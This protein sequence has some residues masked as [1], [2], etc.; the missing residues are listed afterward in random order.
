MAMLHDP[1]TREAIKAR[2]VALRPDSPRRWGRMTTDQML[3]HLNAG[4]DNCLGRH[5]VEPLRLPLPHALVKFVVLNLPWRKGK[6]PTAREFLAREQY[7]FEAEKAK[8]LHLIDEV[9]ARPLDGAWPDS[10]FMGPMTGKDWSR[11]GAK[12]LDHH[13]TQFGV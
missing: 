2:I 8:L 10:P 5:H 13:L 6:T 3:W 1:A 9:T 12:H 7:D 4:I 11:M